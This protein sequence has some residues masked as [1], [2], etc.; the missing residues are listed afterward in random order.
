[1]KKALA[2]G[3]MAFI[4]GPR[5]VGKTTL[6]LSLLG[7]AATERHPASLQ[8]GRPAIRGPLEAGRA[9]GPRTAPHLRRGPQVRPVAQPAQG[10]LRHREV[11]PAHRRHGVGEAGLLPEGG[12]SLANRYRHFRLHPFSL[13][14]LDLEALRIASRD[15]AAVRRLSRTALSTGR[16]GAPDLAAGSPGEG[17][18]GGSP[19]SGAGPRGEPRRAA[20]RPAAGARRRAVVGRQPAPG[21]RG[22]S[23]DG[24]A[25]ADHP[26]E[27]VRL[28]PPAPVRLAP[29]PGGEEG[30]EALPVGLVG[31][32]RSRRALREP[33]GMPAA[34]VLPLDR[35]HRGLPRW[36]CA[37]S[38]TPTGARW[39]SSSCGGGR[40]QFA[41]ECKTGERAISPARA[42][43]RRAN[44]HSAVLPGPSRRTS[45]RDPAR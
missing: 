5:Q 33:G 3:K 7:P 15:A 38:G 34:Q 31:R 19:R 6:A 4:G 11:L 9:P 36:S 29:D 44:A 1:M 30:E 35:G 45:L 18:P 2:A 41:V 8:L 32:R 17:D 23:Q 16:G 12:D 28:L 21:S 22:R 43:L 39:T 13:R 14:E 42:L 10:H 40:P 20:C 24:R 26:G 37:T 25:M 27:P